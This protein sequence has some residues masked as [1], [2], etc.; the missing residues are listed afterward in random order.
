MLFASSNDWSSG[1]GR[2]EVQFRLRVFVSLGQTLDSYGV[3]SA[4]HGSSHLLAFLSENQLSADDQLFALRYKDLVIHMAFFFSYRQGGIHGKISLTAYV[5]AALLET[6]I[7]T[8]VGR[9]TKTARELGMQC[10]KNETPWRTS[11][12]MMS[13]V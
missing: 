4:L 13:A 6:G 8:E 2:L 9:P 3:D 1:R 12:F 11:S 10:E 5:V 7:T